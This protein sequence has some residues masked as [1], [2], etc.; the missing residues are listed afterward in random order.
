MQ[1]S[2]KSDVS[3]LLAS[4]VTN[5]GHPVRVPTQASRRSTSSDW[6]RKLMTGRAQFDA[7]V[8]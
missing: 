7:R 1:R 6:R 8:A 5:G 4:A 2:R 3:Q